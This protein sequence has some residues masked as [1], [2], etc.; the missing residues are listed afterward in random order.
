ML[1]TI[2]IQTPSVGAT[3]HLVNR[4]AEN[5]VSLLGLIRTDRPNS[6][7]DSELKPRYRIATAPAACPH[8]R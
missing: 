4:S 7:E 3:G 6:H 5:D 1:T 8:R 2:R